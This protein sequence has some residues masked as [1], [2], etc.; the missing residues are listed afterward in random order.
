MHPG[1]KQLCQETPFA[2]GAKGHRIDSD[3]PIILIV[4]H[5]E[6]VMQVF[7]TFRMIDQLS[8]AL[9][10]REAISRQDRSAAEANAIHSE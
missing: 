8:R 5:N 3:H 9:A 2:T 7:G 10:V 6:D 4:N 1:C